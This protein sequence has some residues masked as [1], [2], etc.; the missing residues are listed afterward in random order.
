MDEVRKSVQ[1]YLVVN[2]PPMCLGFFAGIII[3]Y[4]L[5]KIF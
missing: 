2:L 3:G 4:I 5:G 1:D